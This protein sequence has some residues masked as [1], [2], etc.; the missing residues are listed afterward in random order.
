MNYLIPIGCVIGIIIAI[1]K[2]VDLTYIWLLQKYGNIK[3]SKIYMA[4]TAIIGYL[5]CWFLV[6][7]GD[8]IFASLSTIVSIMLIVRAV[9]TFKRLNKLGKEVSE[10]EDP[11]YRALDKYRNKI[12]KLPIYLQVD[13]QEILEKKLEEKGAGLNSPLPSN[14]EEAKD[15][16][17][18]T[19]ETLLEMIDYMDNLENEEKS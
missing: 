11:A 18:K 15:Q 8:Y 4:S 14:I 16:A 6:L 19:S 9:T 1:Y 2:I 7:R 3:G 17:K 10:I 13:V 5:M 12:S